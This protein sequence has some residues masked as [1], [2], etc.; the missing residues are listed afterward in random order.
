MEKK[1]LHPRTNFASS[2]SSLMNAKSKVYQLWSSRVVLRFTVVAEA[3]HFTNPP[4]L[5]RCRTALWSQPLG[6]WFAGW[7]RK[8]KAISWRSRRTLDV[9]LGEFPS[10]MSHIW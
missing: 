2:W 4:M 6:G 7:L 9:R 10:S 3:A 1:K 5:V 8:P